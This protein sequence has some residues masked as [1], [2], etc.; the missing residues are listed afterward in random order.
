[1]HDICLAII[2]A[3]IVCSGYRQLGASNISNTSLMNQIQDR[4]FRCHVMSNR[5]ADCCRDYEKALKRLLISV[6][7]SVE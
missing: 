6:H 7:I 3:S 1:M 5:V 4:R 2:H